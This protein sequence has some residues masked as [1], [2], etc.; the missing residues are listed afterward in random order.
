[1]PVGAALLSGC[2]HRAIEVETPVPVALA[3]AGFLS[4]VRPLP[5]WWN[6]SQ[7]GVEVEADVAEVNAYARHAYAIVCACHRHLVA[8]L[9][10]G[11]AAAIGGP[12]CQTDAHLNAESII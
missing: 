10:A 7:V 1:M 5:R 4:D 11:G 2:H 6:T 12:C 9:P 8:S 3:A